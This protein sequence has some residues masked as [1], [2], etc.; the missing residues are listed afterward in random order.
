MADT[1]ECKMEESAADR[2]ALLVNRKKRLTILART[3]PPRLFLAPQR[4]PDDK[5]EGRS[6]PEPISEDTASQLVASDP[7]WA[8]PEVLGP[9]R[10]LIDAW[11]ERR[12]LGPL[13]RILGGWPPNGLTD[14]AN[15]LLSA[16]QLARAVARD[17]STAFEWELLS[18]V[19]SKLS[20][21]LGSPFRG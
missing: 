16:I 4:M 10:Y 3:N 17:V 1:L 2:F 11:C 14:G 7:N 9:V 21:L 5:G 19:E 6:E 20:H 15:E 12:S 18:A 8:C 13:G